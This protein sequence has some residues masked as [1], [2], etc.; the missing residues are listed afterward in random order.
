[1]S[2][3]IKI[4]AYLVKICYLFQQFCQVVRH[5]PNKKQIIQYALSKLAITNYVRYNNHKFELDTL[6]TYYSLLLEISAEFDKH[7]V[8]SY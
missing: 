7:I 2:F 6:F 3:I 8:N 4:N 5:K 1:M